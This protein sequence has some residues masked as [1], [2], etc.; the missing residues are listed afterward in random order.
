MLLGEWEDNVCRQTICKLLGTV[1]N[2][3]PLSN[4]FTFFY[5]WKDATV[6]KL[7]P[8][9]GELANEKF[10]SFTATEVRISVFIQKDSVVPLKQVK[11][12]F[13]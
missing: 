11:T 1:E 6:Y 5:H 4:F 10:P 13:V 9:D 3:D 7:T 2:W 8:T 12:E